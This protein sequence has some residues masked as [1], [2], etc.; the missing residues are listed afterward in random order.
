MTEPKEIPPKELVAIMDAAI[1]KF[2]GQSNVLEGALGAL[3]FG[4]R[5]GWRP[6][7]L[8]HSSATIKKYEQILGVSFREVLPEEGDKASKSIAWKGAKKIGN[9]WKAVTGNT[10]NVRSGEVS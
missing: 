2:K 1:V 3:V 4:R 8:M 7:F 6:L 5:I 10:K 9:F